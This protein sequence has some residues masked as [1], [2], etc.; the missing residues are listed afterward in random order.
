MNVPGTVRVTGTGMIR[1]K[2][3]TTVITLTLEG[4]DPDYAKTLERSAAD[5][6][7]IADALASV[8]FAREELKTRS[9]R[10]ETEYEGYQ[11]EG[12]YRQRL[13][14]YRFRHELRLRFPS[15]DER[16]GRVLS[17]L[18]SADLTPELG[19]GYTVNDP[20]AAKNAL[21][22][23]AVADAKEKAEA[24]VKA[25][26]TKLGATRHIGYSLADNAFSVQPVMLAGSARKLAM[27]AA[28]LEIVPEEIEAQDVVTVVWE[29][30]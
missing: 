3:D 22:A 24:L 30:E 6:G 5:T 27:D 2:P 21:I 26:G 11:D 20:E 15:D 4:M 16:L 12:A 23:A 9:F 13:I 29:I 10:V 18:A 8:G 17:A 14:G 25:S 28:N 19:I 7:R 1:L